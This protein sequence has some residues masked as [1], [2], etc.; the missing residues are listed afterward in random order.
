MN[1]IT[2]IPKN[3][4][5]YIQKIAETAQGMGLET[6]IVGGYVRDLILQRTVKDIDIVC[7]GNGIELAQAC[8]K[9]IK[10]STTV[11]VFK[12]F[13]TA[14]FKAQDIEFEFVGARKESYMEQSRKPLVSQGT[15]ADDQIRRDFTINALAI[16]L[17]KHNFG[18]LIDPFNGLQHL[19]EK[20]IQTP[21]NANITFSDDP[22]R[23]LRAIRFANQLG[24]TIHPQT[25][26]AIKHNKQRLKIISMERVRDEINK[27]LMCDTP[28]IGFKLLFYSE[29]LPV[30]FKELNNLYGI[31][32]L[33]G[34]AHK[35]NFFHTLQ[36]LD[37]ICLK[38]NNLWL[39][40]AALLHDIAKPPTKRFE[41]GI[42]WT[43]HGHEVLGAKMTISIFN[44]FKLPLAEPLRFVAKMVELHL[45]PI[46]LTKEAVTDSGIRRLLFDAGDDLDAL[47]TLCYA[48][49]TSKNEFRVKRYYD[50]YMLLQQKLVE[51]EEK[52]RL[53][54][55]QPPITGE[56]IMQTFDI[57]P[58]KQVGIIKN[59]VREAILDGIIPNE[60]EA[61]FNYMLE[62]AQIIGFKPVM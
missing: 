50:N 40:W 38:T 57:K 19:E 53:K 49:I 13:G 3:H 10:N 16:S 47:M 46:A 54:N 17:Q 55:W 34:I 5:P 14:M 31:D 23:M 41:E 18:E 8:S 22:L 24:F 45:R 6:Y 25:F 4:L 15:L 51:I 62:Q 7:V 32:T 44:R 61:A 39:R 30:F 59:A 1:L 60:Y 35:D 27:I 20:V 58:S 43:F 56:I 37:N 28:S 11:T 21:T 48:D 12:N 29:L 52:D 2:A 42:G 26:E 9:K 36:V 33:N